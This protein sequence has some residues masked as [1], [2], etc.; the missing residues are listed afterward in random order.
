MFV[1]R[2]KVIIFDF[3]ETLVTAYSVKWSQHQETARRFYGV[4]LTTDTIK[5]Y[6]G[7]PFEEMIGLFYEH[8]DTV[9]NMS[10]NYHSLDHLYHKYPYAD[11]IDVLNFLIKRRFI[12]GLVTSMTKESVIADMEESGIPYKK[13]EFLQGSKDCKFHKPDPR[14]FRSILGKLKKMKIAKNKVLYVGD[15]IRDMQAA[16]GAG[17]HF[18][19]IPNGLTTGKEFKKNGAVIFNSLSDLIR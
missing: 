1:S 16:L 4:N 5:K 9:E 19:A 14:V 17:I 15:D 18:A 8:K 12:L 6:W 3:D 11:T 7:M 13:F 2:Y 10:R